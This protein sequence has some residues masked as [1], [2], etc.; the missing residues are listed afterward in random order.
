MRSKTRV[1]PPD[2]LRR[3]LP[4]LMALQVMC[5]HNR[6]SLSSVHP[7][8]Q[9]CGHRLQWEWKLH[10]LN[11]VHSKASRRKIKLLFFGNFSPQ[12]G[13]LSQNPWGLKQSSPSVDQSS[14][15]MLQRCFFKMLL[16]LELFLVYTLWKRCWLPKLDGEVVRPAITDLSTDASLWGKNFTDRRLQ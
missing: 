7:C 3:R 9:L 10:E 6:V 13:G 8:L 15:H 4:R 14:T 2:Y 16:F 5:G 11:L 1:W 12:K